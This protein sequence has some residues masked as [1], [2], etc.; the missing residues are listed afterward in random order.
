MLSDDVLEGGVFEFIGISI[1]SD[2]LSH[3]ACG[4][5]VIFSVSN[6]QTHRESSGRPQ[7]CKALHD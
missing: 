6:Q 3:S 5:F 1:L 4:H 7:N 2:I